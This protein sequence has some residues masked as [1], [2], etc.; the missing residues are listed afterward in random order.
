MFACSY[1]LRKLS[2][3]GQTPWEAVQQDC[4]YCHVSSLVIEKISQ[5]T[6]WKYFSRMCSTY[7]F[8]VMYCL[9]KNILD[10]VIFRFEGTSKY[11]TELLIFPLLLLKVCRWNDGS[12][13]WAWVSYVQHLFIMS[14][15]RTRA[16]IFTSFIRLISVRAVAKNNKESFSIIFLTWNINKTRQKSIVN[17]IS[18][19]VR[20]ENMISII[21][22]RFVR[23]IYNVMENKT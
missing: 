4:T 5:I 6:L 1:F 10:Y 8:I 3:F 21:L 14:T 20:L 9:V 13:C 15:T 17:L 23:L 18:T 22:G 19:V 2:C 12:A 7:V 16:R 11:R